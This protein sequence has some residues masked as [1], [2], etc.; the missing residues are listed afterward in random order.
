MSVIGLTPVVHKIFSFKV[1]YFYTFDILASPR[2]WAICKFLMNFGRNIP[3]TVLNYQKPVSPVE[4]RTKVK[5]RFH[6]CFSVD[7]IRLGLLEIFD[8][9]KVPKFGN[10]IYLVEFRVQ[11][12]HLHFGTQF[13]S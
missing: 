3:Q 10:Y 7:C 13:T 9:N 1:I 2:K 12:G 8:S 11:E 4:L 5:Q 6:L